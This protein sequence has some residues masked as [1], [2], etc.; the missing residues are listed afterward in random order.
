MGFL[1]AVKVQPLKLLPKFWLYTYIDSGAMYRAATLH[2]LDHK[3]N[4]ENKADLLENLKSL[5]FPLI[6]IRKPENRRLS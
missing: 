4:L 3:V 1:D 6:S 5:R 2:F